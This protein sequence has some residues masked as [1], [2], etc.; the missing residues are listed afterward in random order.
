MDIPEYLGLFQD[1]NPNLGLG[2]LN[3]AFFIKYYNKN[4][5]FLC[6]ESSLTEKLGKNGSGSYPRFGGFHNHI[7]THE[8]Q[9]W[10][11]V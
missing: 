8:T 10:V 2:M 9:I 11:W 4:A 1:I 5:L 3:R 6:I 7:H